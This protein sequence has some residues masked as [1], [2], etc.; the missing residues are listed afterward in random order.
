M[1]GLLLNYLLFYYAV[2]LVKYGFILLCIQFY[3]TVFERVN[4]MILPLLQMFFIRVWNCS[5]MR[6]RCSHV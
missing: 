3:D 1:R 4:F 5:K 6:S 2:K